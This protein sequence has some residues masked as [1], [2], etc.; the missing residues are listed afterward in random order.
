MA[1]N[2][3]EAGEGMTEPSGNARMRPALRRD[4]RD[5]VVRGNKTASPRRSPPPL[6][7]PRRSPHDAALNGVAVAAALL[8]G[9]LSASGWAPAAK[10]QDQQVDGG[11]APA[12]YSPNVPPE[13]CGRCHREHYA[14][15]SVSTHAKVAGRLYKS[16]D[17][18]GCVA[19]HGP[20]ADHAQSG[21]RDLIARFTGSPAEVV[22]GACLQCHERGMRL[23]WRG[24]AHESRNITCT[25]CH[26]IHKEPQP[27]PGLS[28]FQERPLETVLLKKQTAIEVCLRCH[29]QRRAQL[30][31][32]SHM[33][34]REGV[35]TCV[36]CHNP[37]GTAT[38][39]LLVENSINETCY[40]CHAEKRGPFLWEHPPVAEN[41]LN[42]H[43]AH[44]SMHAD[45]LKAR[46]PRLC[47]RCH[48]RSGHQTQPRVARTRLFF[49]TG[50]TNCH[51]RI[52]GSNHPSGVRF[53]R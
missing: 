24:S 18:A 22:E 32:S 8:V 52:H 25:D 21:D 19:C 1:M 6:S 35:L 13:V 16:A 50:C 7:S 34:L 45:L 44:G 43:D 31:R 2:V 10:A 42:C 47:Q 36:D 26:T 28:R 15:W 40:K 23:Y 4:A 37:H 46:A 20:G 27:I 17:K 5:W 14:T 41:C 11:S 12:S 39:A 3:Q 51:S 9:L 49:N 53:H 38:P 30:L 33:P 29:P 48:G